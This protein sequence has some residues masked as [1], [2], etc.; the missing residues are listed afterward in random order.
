M[1]HVGTD[2]WIFDPESPAP[3]RRLSVRE[4]ARIQTFP[5]NFIFYYKN[6]IAAYKMIGNAVPVNFSYAIAQAIKEDLFSKKHTNNRP[7]Y[8]PLQLSLNL[9]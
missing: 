8:L 4:C 7:N 3:Y 9:L 6:I 1:I 5:D 2:K